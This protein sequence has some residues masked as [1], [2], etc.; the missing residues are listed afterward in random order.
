MKPFPLLLRY[1]L[2]FQNFGEFGI[3]QS[4]YKPRKYFKNNRK[5]TKPF[6][7][8]KRK[9]S[10]TTKKIEIMAPTIIKGDTL[11]VVFKNIRK[12]F[13]ENEKREDKMF[14]SSEVFFTFRK[15]ESGCEIELSSMVYGNHSVAIKDFD[16]YDANGFVK[17]ARKFIKGI[18]ES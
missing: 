5:K 9:K 7:L 2:R 18:K 11:A 13:K 8:L 14:C 1:T 16:F 10:K 3:L 17:A 4:V 6:H 12:N 15:T